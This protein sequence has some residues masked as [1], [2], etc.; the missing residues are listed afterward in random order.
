MTQTNQEYFPSWDDMTDLERAQCTFW[1]MYKD[2]HGVRPR[3]ICTDGWTL[4]DFGRE[5]DRLEQMIQREEE[6]RMQREQ[7]AITHFEHRLNQLMQ[8]GAADREV[9]IRWC[10]EADNCRDLEDLAYTN[11]L[12]WNY[13]A[14]TQPRRGDG[15]YDAE[16]SD[17]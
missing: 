17:E 6:L 4:G 12:P 8:L 16:L 14:R 13:L 7:Q 9:A 11:G 3:G 2:A 5:F 15:R 10:M 1:D